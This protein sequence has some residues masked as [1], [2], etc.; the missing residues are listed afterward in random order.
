MTGDFN[1]DRHIDGVMDFNHDGQADLVWRNYT[2][3]ADYIW[4][5]NRVSFSSQ[6]TLPTDTNLNWHIVGPR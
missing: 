5:M 2:T 1:V 4:L 6:S 3:G